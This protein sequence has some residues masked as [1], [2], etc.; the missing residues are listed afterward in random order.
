MTSARIVRYTTSPETADENERLV[1]DV[2][3]ELAESAP[4]GLR[5]ATFRLEDGVTFV[6]VVLTEGDA[7]P[8]PELPE[9][10]AFQADIGDR[11]VTGP[12][13]AAATLVGSYG[14][15]AE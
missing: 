12:T 14:L 3:T 7:E 15:V 10:Q 6:H 5:Y 11:A 8:L 2:F 9:F 13:P 1:R 4:P